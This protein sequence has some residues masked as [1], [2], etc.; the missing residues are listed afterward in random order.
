[1]NR[2]LL[3]FFLLL[4][5]CFTIE[6]FCQVSSNAC[7]SGSEIVVSNQGFG[8]GTFYS[9][10][11][12]LASCDVEPGETFPNSL[13]THGQTQ[14]SVWYKFRISSHRGVKVTLK[15]ISVNHT[16]NSV[17]MAIYYS[18]NCI[19][20]QQSL[21]NVLTPI[22]NFGST[23]NPCTPPG[24]YFIQVVD[25]GS[26]F[27]NLLLELETT[28]PNGLYD[29]MSNP[30]RFNVVNNTSTVVFDATCLSMEDSVELC[31]N[32][33]FNNPHKYNKTAW[34]TFTTPFQL[35]GVLL[36]LNKFTNT[37][38]GDTGL[39]GYSLYSGNVALNG[40]TSLRSI[41]SCDTISLRN[42]SNSYIPISCQLESNVVYSLK[43]NFH[44][45]FK[46]NL[47][48]G[49]RSFTSPTTKG[50]LP[51]PSNIANDNKL[52]NI[53]DRV[54]T[55]QD[56]F[57]C[58]S[59][60][61]NYIAQ[62]CLLLQ[63]TATGTY[64][65]ST[66]Y[67]FST[68]KPSYVYINTSGINCGSL[69]LKLY[70]KI[71]Q[72]SCSEFAPNNLYISGINNLEMYCLPP[73]EY[74][75]QI[76]GIYGFDVIS[77]TQNPF[78]Q[79]SSNFNVKFESRS[80]PQNTLFNLTAP[81]K[82]FKFNNNNPLSFYTNYT[83]TPDT[84]NCDNTPIPQNI[85]CTTN[86]SKGIYKQ[87]TVSDSSFLTIKNFNQQV[88]SIP[89]IFRVGTILYQGDAEALANAQ[90]VWSYPNRINGLTPISPCMINNVN[91]PVDYCLTP[92]TYTIA[93][94]GDSTLN[95][96]ID[97]IGIE[98]M[99]DMNSRFGS[100]QTAQ[101]MGNIL[102]SFRI[103]NVTTINSQIDTFTCRDNAVVI[104]GHTP[105]ESKASYLEF[106]ISQPTNNLRVETGSGNYTMAIFSGRASTGINNLRLYRICG[107]F[108]TPSVCEPIP[109]GWYTVVVYGRGNGYD[110]RI[111]KLLN[112]TTNFVKF[113]QISTTPLNPKNYNRPHL[114]AVDTNTGLPY[115]IAWDYTQNNATFPA[116]RKYYGLNETIFDCTPDTPFVGYGIDMCSGYNRVSYHVIN[117][118][119]YSYLNIYNVYKTSI[120]SGD[121]RTDSVNFLNKTPIAACKE[122][123][124]ELEICNLV[125]GIYTIVI[126]G[127]DSHAGTGVQTRI[128]VDKV[129]KSRFD[130]ITNAYDFG[131][132]PSN[133]IAINGKPGDINPID[134]NRAASND[135][136][137]CTTGG[138][139]VDS[140]ARS[141]NSNGDSLI[142]TPYNT[143]DSNISIQEYVS[144]RRKELKR[145]LWYTF[146]TV[147]NVKE[148]I[149]EA[150]K[151]TLDYDSSLNIY[152]VRYLGNSQMTFDQLKNANLFDSTLFVSEVVGQIIPNKFRVNFGCNDLQDTNRFFVL[153]E[154]KTSAAYQT[155][156]N[157]QFDLKISVENHLP[158]TDFDF[159][160][161][162]NHFATINNYGQ[163]YNGALGDYRCATFSR[164]YPDNLWSNITH[165]KTPTLWYSFNVYPSVQSNLRIRMVGDNIPYPNTFMQIVPKLVLL[166]EAI[167]GDSVNGLVRIPLSNLLVDSF[168]WG[169]VCLSELDSGKYYILYNN[170]PYNQIPQFDYGYPQVILDTLRGN[171]CIT[172][173]TNQ[174]GS[175]TILR[176]TLSIQCHDIGTDYGEFGPLLTCPPYT[177]TQDYKSS[178]FRVDITG[179]DTVNL[180]AKFRFGNQ[181]IFFRK[182]TGD[183]NSMVNDGCVTD[184]A[185]VNVYS[186]LY[187]GTSHYFQVFTPSHLNGEIQ[188]EFIT[189]N[190]TDTC[191][192]QNTC[193]T[194][195]DFNYIFDCSIS[196]SIYFNNL[197]TFGREVRYIWDFG[198][199]GDT[200]HAIAPAY[201]YPS[202]T[203][204]G[205]YPVTLTVINEH[206]NDTAVY[207]S[208][209]IM[210]AIIDLNLGND[211]FVCG[212]NQVTL[213]P[214]VFLAATYTWDD[215]STNPTRTV[216]DTGT[217]TYYVTATM[218]GCTDT[219]TI[220]VTFSP[221]NNT[222][223]DTIYQC[224]ANIP[225]TLNA[226]RNSINASY[227]WFNA[228]ITDSIVVTSPGWYWV[229]V[230]LDS[231]TT[232]DSFY[233]RLVDSTVRLLPP[234]TQFCSWTTPI[235][236]DATITGGKNYLWSTTDTTSNITV[237]NFG[238]YWVRT[239]L[240][241]CQIS[242]TMQLGLAPSYNITVYDT[243]CNG[244]NYTLP[245]NRIVSISG[246]YTDTLQSRWGCDS[247]ITTHLMVNPNDTLY[248]QIGICYQQLP[249]TWNGNTY[250]QAGN[251]SVVFSN[252][253]GCDST[254]HLTLNID[255]VIITPIADSICT[256]ALPYI[257]NGR[258]L[259]A[260][261]NYSDTLNNVVG[262]DSIVL[263]QL[264]VLDVDNIYLEDGMCTNG[265]GYIFGDTTLYNSGNYVR[266][267]TNRW[268]CDSTVT[269]DL[270]FS[271]PPNGPI[272]R[273]PLNV[274]I[275]SPSPVLTAN[276]TNLLWYTQA[277]GGVGT[278]T[279]PSVN[280]STIG[281][282]TYY[283]SQ[284]VGGC[285]SAR[286][287]LIVNIIN[288]PT[289]DFRVD[290]IGCSK[291]AVDVIALNVLNNYNY[292]WD[293]DGGNATIIGTNHYSV[294]WNTGG[295]KYITL[296]A[297]GTYCNSDTVTK[298]VNIINYD[299]F[300]DT[301]Y[302]DFLCVN[303]ITRLG[304][305]NSNDSNLSY[306]WWVNGI[307]QSN[308]LPYFDFSFA[309][310]DYVTVK[311]TVNHAICGSLS[312]EKNMYVS[313]YPKAS[314]QPTLYE[315]CV[316]DTLELWNSEIIGN[317]TYTWAPVEAIYEAN[318]PNGYA[319]VLTTNS[320][321]IILTVSNKYG[322]AVSD[323]AYLQTVHCCDVF[324]PTA[325]SPNRDGL[326]DL[327]KVVLKP[328]QE[329][330]ELA[331]YN[332][333]GQ[334]VFYTQD[335]NEGWDGS[336]NGQPG[337]LGVY[338][339]WFKYKCTDGKVHTRKSDLTLIR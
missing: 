129:G 322:C 196:D 151:K 78:Y 149:L 188:A 77:C 139:I 143:V 161:T 73:G 94:L 328:N 178:W 232:R 235:V 255:S 293:W 92:G 209:V 27:D 330:V 50:P 313:S 33:K 65:M 170:S 317:Y 333:N 203:T 301:I 132:V 91:H 290:S 148:I 222:I 253:Y 199:N 158:T 282:T 302:P 219:D 124:S 241:A 270:V 95:G 308:N 167:P 49:M 236:L 71:A 172:A 176:D 66:F 212:T 223:K 19:P 42:I 62:N 264:Q 30:Y 267:F 335:P 21:S 31:N 277:S 74:T 54:I 156:P 210:P 286:V 18:G 83:S 246:V 294:I 243:I 112:R 315:V 61:S 16:P 181:P 59:L 44:E 256:N 187:P 230:T 195:A 43:L 165:N 171:Y 58:E 133:Q 291:S 215:N 144:T 169:V 90:N 177:N 193:I 142:L 204:N 68:A 108:F 248:E 157:V 35:N 105:C 279:P 221:L 34:F 64:N 295:P 190:S 254:I 121:I 126:Y 299:L 4:N 305:N 217:Q 268:G 75:L 273:S 97:S 32:N 106:Y 185:T 118:P 29:M 266:T 135:F 45:D 285:E 2:I 269:L 102:D 127:K 109:V 116:T 206:C 238:T 82:V 283:V 303:T 7:G 211:I 298:Q 96:F 89:N 101:N 5:S 334:Q 225:I 261:G 138:S 304:S 130:F 208:N 250:T 154:I 280:T 93:T 307:P 166:K 201:K 115:E 85:P 263:L 98:I 300:L 183:C 240:G 226:H 47:S 36:Y 189:S 14:R 22:S 218:F 234:D 125:P 194:N 111:N 336:Y 247:I 289:V 53:N 175:N 60:H 107:Q 10:T 287:P 15:P 237:N 104:D 134:A 88:S 229:D 67:T 117:V 262:C 164:P 213:D 281:S 122:E 120:F 6:V 140:V 306:Q 274:C 41:I 79:F 276:G 20:D 272:V 329:F 114:A 296:Y 312:F 339:F 192:S 331:I 136:I 205:V 1:M 37:V 252:K 163:I 214:G 145:T 23:F 25:D 147:G 224:E 310:V 81:G 297:E 110:S 244:S 314:I 174:M 128:M 24:D 11:F 46:E 319:K 200:S 311:V 131:I 123:I 76:S 338:Y 146:Q 198:Y 100:P 231:C 275:N 17:G 72:N 179:T 56:N 12:S 63:D 258:T 180:T 324:Y 191:K 271:N 13:I 216:S 113:S 332:R 70:N 99:P 168:I 251:Y 249:F 173:I 327:F 39:I 242:D 55:K 40:I 3:I 84:I 186:C 278:P 309:N 9:D 8:L 325:F 326:N 265:Q 239:Q 259:T 48:L 155:R 141:N 103:H 318:N 184:T 26:S 284:T 28:A 160:S 51:I 245:S 288:R 233:V 80:L 316:G 162:A 182:M 159:Y 137:Y 119:Y 69:Q 323:T 220:Q 86:Y 227:N 38:L 197:S 321:S 260:S 87:F 202:Q 320:D 152:V 150:D 337:D 153:V 257:F 57:S 292:I 207:R 52:G 228:A